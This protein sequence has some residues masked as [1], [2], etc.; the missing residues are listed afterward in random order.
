[1]GECPQGGDQRVADPLSPYASQSRRL[2]R[3]GR[4]AQ[5]KLLTTLRGEG[6]LVWSGGSIVATYELDVFARGPVRSASG[7]IEGDLSALVERPAADD[8]EPSAGCRLQLDDGREI[9]IDLVSLEAEG[10]D[11]EAGDASVGVLA[12]RADQP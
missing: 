5:L 1:M 11:F 7:Q 10:A 6:A 8:G 2:W 3:S 9:A 4:A 12:A